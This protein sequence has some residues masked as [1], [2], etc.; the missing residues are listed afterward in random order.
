ML[1][2]NLFE[3]ELIKELVSQELLGMER[4]P[5]DE[6]LQRVS[7]RDLLE[8]LED[9]LLEAKTLMSFKQSKMR[10]L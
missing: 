6:S 7:R 8:D 3:I 9:K 4:D 10:D 1:E 2:L 5:A